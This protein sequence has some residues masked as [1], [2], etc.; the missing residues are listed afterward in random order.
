MPSKTDSDVS[1]FEE[2]SFMFDP[3][4][5][6]S[7]DLRFPSN[8]PGPSS[9]GFVFD[10]AVDDLP[11]KQRSIRDNCRPVALSLTAWAVSVIFTVVY[12]LFI[13]HVLFQG[14]PVIGSWTFDASLTNLLLS[15]CS[16]LY[17]MLLAYVV[18]SLSDAL[19]WS[20]ASRTGGKGGASASSFFQLSPATDWFSILKLILRG[21]FRSNWGLI[22]LA[23]PFMGL[24]F[25][26]I[27]KFQ[28]SFEDYFIKQGVSIDV[29]A[30]NIPPDVSVLGLISTTYLDGFFDT[31]AQQLLNYPRY[32]TGWKMDGC[33]GA[34]SVSFLPGGMEIARKVGP[35][36]N[37]TILQGGLFNQTETIMIESAPGLVARFDPVPDGFEFDLEQDCSVYQT[38]LGDALQM[39][40]R[41]MGDSVA[42]GWRACP[43]ATQLT[44][45]C[46]TRLAWTKAPIVSKTL[47]T[48]YRQTATTMYSQKDLSIQHVEPVSKPARFPMLEPDMELIW[49]RVFRPRPSPAQID[50]ESINVT[51]SRMAW[52]YRTYTEFFPD[53]QMHVEL[54]QNFLAVPLQFAV[55]AMQYANYTLALPEEKRIFP[56][57]LLTRATGGRSIKRFVSQP[58]TVVVFI[59]SGALVVS[60]SG[61]GFWWMLSQA[62]PLPKPSGIVELDFVSR[63]SDLQGRRRTE[64]GDQEQFA[65]LVHDIGSRK[66][67]SAWQIIQ[68]LQERR[69]GLAPVE[70]D[71]ESGGAKRVVPIL[72]LLSDEG[73][74]TATD[75]SPSFKGGGFGAGT[76]V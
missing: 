50:L 11:T 71:E 69:L 26:S 20:L 27:L 61:V 47:F 21:R 56:P 53:N 8:E 67:Y 68:A 9:P 41:Q 5:K 13:Y 22:R 24:G 33:T 18:M 2:I 62:H 48:A 59:A 37:S 40:K 66:K 12:S 6:I 73:A 29:Y 44:R 7:L 31:W 76:I 16:Q 74:L 23:L 30:G 25:G 70:V 19:R 43:S 60:L 35:L 75:S 38:P 49:D 34:C 46:A 45:G 42:A 55:T 51:I 63:V 52:K 15:I 1:S 72:Y 14:N 39:C 10:P 3:D 28:N 4:R 36:L 65:D 58:W 17:G 57:E 54:L 64:R 32:A